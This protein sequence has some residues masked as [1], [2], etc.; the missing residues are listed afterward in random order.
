MGINLTINRAQRPDLIERNKRHFRIQ[1]YKIIIVLLSYIIKKKLRQLVKIVNSEL[2]NIR[3]ILK[4]IIAKTGPDPEKNECL[5]FRIKRCK[6]LLYRLKKNF[7][8]W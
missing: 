6:I 4:L 8:D 3:H 7:D 1:R 2:C 5:H